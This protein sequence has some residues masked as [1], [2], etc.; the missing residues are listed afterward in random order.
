MSLKKQTLALFLVALGVVGTASGLQAVTS[1]APCPEQA[2]HQGR[3][4]AR[5]YQMKSGQCL[6]SVNDQESVDVYR[7]YSISSSGLFMVFNAFEM[8]GGTKESDGSRA[9]FFFP[10]KHAPS[11]VEVP[12]K[13]I[14][15]HTVSGQEIL[16]SGKTARIAS[17]HG[18]KFSEDPE[19]IPDN[20]GGVELHSFQG[21]V[22]DTGWQLGDVGYSRK[23]RKRSSTFMDSQGRRCAVINQ[24]IFAYDT[25]KA[26][27]E[28]KHETDAELAEFLSEKCPELDLSPLSSS[29]S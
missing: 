10:R 15:V 9:Y 19:V 27:V 7:S 8:W 1:T 3:I 28:L 25:G 29:R 18:A 4:S 5:V 2:V 11:F 12:K 22:L 20:R 16:F 13:G 6:I 23:N 17:M 26:E 24:E 21:I 14:R